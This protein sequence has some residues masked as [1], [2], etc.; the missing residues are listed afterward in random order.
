[1][2]KKEKEGGEVSKTGN[3]ITSRKDIV[4]IKTY[5][6]EVDKNLE[7]GVP[8]GFVNLICGTS[9]TMKSSV[10]FNILYNE[11]LNNNKHAMYL[12]LEQSATS[13]INH[14]I[15]MGFDV[16]KIALVNIK[17]IGKIDEIAAEIKALNKGALIMVDLSVV[18]KEL[19]SLKKVHPDADWLNVIENIVSKLK[20]SE[21]CE[22]FVLDSMSALYALSEFKENPRARLFYTFEYFRDMGVTS[23]FITEVPP[24][25]NSYGEYGVE[26]YLADGIFLLAMKRVGRKVQR[27]ISI[28]KMR[29]TDCNM[30]VYVLSYEQ[31]KFKAL[32]KLI[33]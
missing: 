15:S 28:V 19:K 6:E 11:V 3:I 32:A 23:Y 7:G 20:E 13:I 33:G 29:A 22:L 27:E 9:G 12:S 4:R 31:N 8:S 16:S 30:D 2:P 10:A 17:D 26:D 18:R 25:G 5:I 14:I 21:S 1:M 24:D